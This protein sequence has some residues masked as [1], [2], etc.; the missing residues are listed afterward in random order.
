[1]P[2]VLTVPR[3]DAPPLGDAPPHGTAPSRS[4]VSQAEVLATLRLVQ[5]ASVVSGAKTRM[6]SDNDGGYV[7][8]DDLDRIG[9]AFSLGILDDDNWDVAIASRGIAV[10]QYDDS[11]EGAPS[12]HPKLQFFR[13]R[14][15]AAGVPGTVSIEEIVD[16]HAPGTAPDLILKMDIEGSE[17]DVLE[18]IPAEVLSRFAQIVVEFHDLQRL[19]QRGFHT[20]ATTALTNVAR[21][22]QAIHI[23]GN[24][25]ALIKTIKNVPFPSVLEVSYVSRQLYKFETCMEVFPTAI[26]Q[27]NHGGRPDLFL[28]RSFLELTV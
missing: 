6:G 16:Q 17:W 28:G 14:I 11:I 20:R 15:G 22:H 26:D 1:M 25:H 7:M 21:T 12:R 19:A 10:K 13:S 2:K 18:T 27:P 24:N 5:P 8:L 23:H 4:R 3:D 9:T